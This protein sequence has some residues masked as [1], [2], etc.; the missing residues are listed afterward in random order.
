M[1]K[2]SLIIISILF[3][4]NIFSQDFQDYIVKLNFDTVPCKIVLVKN[5]YIKYLTE[6]SNSQIKKLSILNTD[7]IGYKQVNKDFTVTNYKAFN[8]IPDIENKIPDSLLRFN[9]EKTDS[10]KYVYCQIVGTAKFLSKKVT[11]TIDYGQETKFFQFQDTRI[12]DETTGKVAVF[13]SMIDALNYMGEKGWEFVQAYA[14]TLGNQN[15]YHF[16]LKKEIQ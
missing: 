11:I 6:D 16:L 8:E 7:M 2:L 3:F 9:N 15:V 10:I 13:N 12:K 1:K 5:L 4:N 14:I